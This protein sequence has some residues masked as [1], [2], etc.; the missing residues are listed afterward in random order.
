MAKYRY[1]VITRPVAGQEAEYNRWYSEQ[2]LHDV[3]RV[4]GFVA[5]QRF[6][7]AGESNLPGSY[8]AIYEM[9]TDDP[10][11]ALAE[12]EARAGSPAMPISPALD[13]AN[14]TVALL[15]PITP[16]VAAGQS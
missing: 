1:L 13:I 14:V 3:I 5:A 6:A 9:E 10:Q 2:H 11:A 16:R 7:V 4:P 8:V 12:V 15:A